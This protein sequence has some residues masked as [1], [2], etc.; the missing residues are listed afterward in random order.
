MREAVGDKRHEILKWSCLNCSQKIGSCN[1]NGCFSGECLT[2]GGLHHFIAHSSWL[3]V[4]SCHVTLAR[5]DKVAYK[6]PLK[7]VIKRLSAVCHLQDFHPRLDSAGS[8]SISANHCFIW[9]GKY[10]ISFL[11]TFCGAWKTENYCLQRVRKR[12]ASIRFISDRV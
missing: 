9:L 8:S 3:F 11:H 2:N 1:K 7:Y 6:F 4:D 10:V 5:T 12:T